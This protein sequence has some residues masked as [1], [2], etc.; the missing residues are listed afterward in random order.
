MKK[1]LLSFALYLCAI[2]AIAQELPKWITK[3]TAS[4]PQ[5]SRALSSGKTLDEARHS[6][7]NCLIGVATFTPKEGSYQYRML[8]E[9][10]ERFDQHKA[11][12]AAAE[13]SAYFKTLNT[14][15][16]DTLCWVQCG[17]T[18]ADMQ[19]FID[20]LHEATSQKVRAMIRKADALRE[21]GDIF[22]AA[23]TYAEAI[24]SVGAVLHLPL[25]LD[26]GS[27]MMTQLHD[28]FLHVLDGVTWEWEHA[29][30]PMVQGE[31]LPKAL[32][33]VAKVD[34]KVVPG[35]PVSFKLNPDG[36]MV[37]D[38]I[39]D[40]KGRAK[41]HV[42]LAPKAE[43]GHVLVT[44]NQQKLSRLPQNLFSSELATRVALNNSVAR[45]DLEAFDPNAFFFMDLA[46]E[47][48]QAIGDT[49]QATMERYDLHNVCRRDSTDIVIMLDYNCEPEGEP[50]TG[51]YPMQNFICDMRLKL[52]DLHTETQLM[53]VE[54]QGYRRFLK[55]ST[56]AAVI[57][58][59]TLPEMIKRVRLKFN[60]NLRDMDYDK[61]RLMFSI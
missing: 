30:C 4:D 35:L 23:S 2:T 26:D 45:L 38:D 58:S 22:T 51:K 17:V 46:D 29:T 16:T 14:L 39:T 42:T 10:G 61:R 43:E 41:T 12:L 18:T 50:T 44:L 49:I 7:L 25:T 47:D 55:A 28:R 1:I 59:K 20:S 24:N 32:Y 31:D 56:S 9:G 60:L 53:E 52:M 6:A 19:A 3:P 48:K 13:Q 27:E 37:S 57:R 54:I 11:L 40:D 36:E 15:E 21:E 8:E 5:C 34:D 33:A